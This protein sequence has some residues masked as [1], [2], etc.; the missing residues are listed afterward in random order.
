M[1]VYAYLYSNPLIS[2]AAGEAVWGWEVDR[3]YHDVGAETISKRPQL[4]QLIADCTADPPDYLLIQRLEALG[5]SIAAMGDRLQQLEALGVTVMATEQDYCSGKNQA[6]AELWSLLDQVQAAQQS[7][8]IQQGHA[9]NRIK[10][11]PPPGKAPYGYR[12]SK[13]RYSLD[14]ATAPV[15]QDFVERFLLF[16]SL[17]GAVRYLEK[18]YGKKISV[19]TG[20][21]WLTSPVYR[22]DLQYQ[23]QQIVPN[24]HAAIIS[25]E[26][27][28]QIDRLLRRN[29]SLPPRTASAPRSLA[30]LVTCATC[31]SA[32]KVTRVTRP[33]RAGE[34][35]YLT[36]IACPQRPKCKA[37]A[38]EQV[39]EQTI[40][41]ICTEL[42]QAIA[43]LQGPPVAGIKGAIA[44]QMQAKESVLQQL[45][46]LVDSGILDTE[47]ADLRAYKLRTEMAEMQQKLAQM[48]PVNLAETVQTV[49]IPQF[50]LDLTESERRF[51]LREFIRQIQIERHETDWTLKLIFIF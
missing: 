24:T 47:T 9:R 42:P 26:E 31:Q 33:R 4:K 36:P 12:R 22:G 49:S 45:P 38:Y 25:R 15:V 30:G 17:R 6:V 8:R 3:I 27:A 39:L 13:E 37:I 18:K 14:R 11:L 32:L 28:A 35:L 1:K 29:R 10:A 51:Y 20:R 46:D 50:W 7:H 41:A 43:A 2:P 16:G 21:R 34:Y 44:A 48:P 19:S 5:D 40:Q 23:G